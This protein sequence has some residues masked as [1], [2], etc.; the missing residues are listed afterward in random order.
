MGL[1]LKK[2]SQLPE[3]TL[4]SVIES[5]PNITKGFEFK[6]YCKTIFSVI[7]ESFSLINLNL[8]IFQEFF[9][10]NGGNRHLL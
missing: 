1:C 9:Y 8:K 5:L 3:L 4:Y 6:Y 2:H 10:G 7:S